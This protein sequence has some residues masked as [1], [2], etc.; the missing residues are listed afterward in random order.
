M[1][2]DELYYGL[3]NVESGHIR[4]D[5]HITAMRYTYIVGGLNDDGS[6][7]T[8]AFVVIIREVADGEGGE[9]NLIIKSNRL[10]LFTYDPINFPTGKLL[11]P[12]TKITE[13][14]RLYKHLK[15]SIDRYIEYMNDSRSSIHNRNIAKNIL[16][17]ALNTNKPTISEKGCEVTSMGS[18]RK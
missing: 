12:P 17:D 10:D 11:L 18:R 1:N 8:D 6:V 2:I 13:T 14:T 15:N 9:V 16:K 5:E 3:L 7:L 4:D